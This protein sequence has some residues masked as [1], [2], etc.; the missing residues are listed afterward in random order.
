MYVCLCRGVTNRTIRRCVAEGAR[1]VAEVGR[2]C[3]GAGTVC[4]SCT[5]DIRD[6]I[7]AETAPRLERDREDSLAAK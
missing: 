7:A 6:L 3:G 4:G 2:R 1:T 5:T